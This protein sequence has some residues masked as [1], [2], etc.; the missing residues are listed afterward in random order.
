MIING[1]VIYSRL[2][3]RDFMETLGVDWR[4]AQELARF[5]LA[6]YVDDLEYQVSSLERSKREHELSADA[7]HQQIVSAI[8]LIDDALDKPRISNARATLRDVKN[9]LENW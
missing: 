5:I 1:E 6:D 2:S 4:D 9:Q 8:N 7:Y 3:A